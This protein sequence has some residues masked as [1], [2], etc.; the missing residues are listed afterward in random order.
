M[1]DQA[2][3]LRDLV[4]RESPG[5]PC[6]RPVRARSTSCKSIS[7]TSGKG[8]VGKTNIALFVAV[9][10]S[11]ARK[12]V[13]LMDA[14]LGLANVHILL[15]I[16]PKF[17][18][19]HFIDGECTLEKV[20]CRGP[21]GIDILPGASGLEKLANLDQGRLEYLQKEFT[22]I[23]REY[24]YLIVDTGAGIGSV[25]TRFASTTDITLLVMT[26]EPTS[27]ADAYAMVKVLYEKG[28]QKVGV[29]VNMALSDR[30]GIETFDRLNALVVKFLKRPLEK[31]GILPANRELSKYIRMQKVFVV[32]KAQDQFTLK[33][34]GIVQKISGLSLTGKKGFFGKFL[35]RGVSGSE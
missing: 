19:S 31:F 18:I 24:D 26:P 9:T 27:L 35:N 4:R 28:V 13:L 6:N 25:V 14:D 2:Q 23:E 22:E 34:R 17:N 8:G 30:D 3:N 1:N 33:V 12:R 20:I 16:A 7:V 15:G 32:E 21:G 5:T 29:I 11:T 10:L